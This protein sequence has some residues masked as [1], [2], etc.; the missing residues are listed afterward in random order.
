M[1]ACCGI[2]GED[3]G[4]FFPRSRKKVNTLFRANLGHSESKIAVAST[5]LILCLCRTINGHWA[6]RNV[7]MIFNKLPNKIFSQINFIHA[8][9]IFSSSRFCP[10]RR[11]QSGRFFRG[12]ASRKSDVSNNFHSCKQREATYAQVCPHRLPCLAEFFGKLI[13][14]GAIV[15][16]QKRED[17]PLRFIYRQICRQNFACFFRVSAFTGRFSA[18][19]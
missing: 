8:A 11:A 13:V 16:K 1:S 9:T 15:L 10:H 3:E 17:C 12:C 2:S 6:C 4:Y 18:Y 19:T 7:I 5:R 14:S